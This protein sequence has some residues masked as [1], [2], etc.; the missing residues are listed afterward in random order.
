MKIK[1]R[2]AQ[3]RYFEFM[4]GFISSAPTSAPTRGQRPAI[5]RLRTSL[6][7]LPLALAT[8][9]GAPAG[10][11][12]QE[13]GSPQAHQAAAEVYPVLLAGIVEQLTAA[14]TNALWP[15]LSRDLQAA[16]PGLDEKGLAEL[17]EE[18]DRIHREILLEAMAKTVPPLFA[19][20]FTAEELRELAAFYRTP[21]GAKA[22]QAMQPIISR[23]VGAITPRSNELLAVSLKAFDAELQRRGR[24]R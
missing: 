1:M 24:K 11:K 15:K 19:S 7:A 17:R 22:A 18:L 16:N 6:F 8:V 20:V 4:S 13:V 14:M 5:G 12:A 21:V 2:C 10:A 9:F 3:A 23:T